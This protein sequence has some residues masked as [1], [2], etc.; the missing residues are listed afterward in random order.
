MFFKK[1]IWDL[2]HLLHCLLLLPTLRFTW[3]GFQLYWGS[4]FISAVVI[5]LQKCIYSSCHCSCLQTEVHRQII[6]CMLYVNY[7]LNNV[8]LYFLQ[9]V[10]SFVSAALTHIWSVCCL[11]AAGWSRLILHASMFVTKREI[12]N[13]AWIFKRVWSSDSVILYD[14]CLDKTIMQHCWECKDI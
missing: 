8:N 9:R 6:D 7:S 10:L 13:P 4:F 2:L 3:R 1:L 14:L 12:I 5:L 11:S